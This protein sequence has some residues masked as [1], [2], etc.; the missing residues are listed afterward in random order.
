MNKTKHIEIIDLC[1]SDEDSFIEYCRWKHSKCTAPRSKYTEYCNKHNGFMFGV[2]ARDSDVW[3]WII[4]N[5][6]F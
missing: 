1:S 2:E 4:R 5:Q 6:K 3:Y